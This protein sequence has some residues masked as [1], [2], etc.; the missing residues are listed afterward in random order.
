[1]KN[2]GYNPELEKQ[3]QSPEDWV[4][5]GLS[6]KCIAIIKEEDRE[7]YLPQ[8]ELQRGSEDLMDC[9]SRG[10]INILETKFNYL[11]SN[12]KITPA[13]K[14]WLIDNGYFT[15]SGI[16]FSDAFVAI[17]SGTTKQGNSMKAPLEAI[18]KNGLVP[19]SLLPLDPTMTFNDYHNPDRITGSM[20]ALGQQFLKRFGMNYERVDRDD[21]STLLME[22]LLNV[23][24]YAWPNPENG[25]YPRT[26]RSANHVWVNF[27]NKYFAFDNYLDDGK[28]EDWIK[29]LAPDYDFVGYG[30]RLIISEKVILKK[31]WL[32][33][34][35][36]DLWRFFVDIISK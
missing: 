33:Q 10:P 11:V 22:D 3:Q 15:E 19:K 16:S 24:G 25:I 18:R 6:A 36:S 32:N 12:N 8:G 29:Q 1:M 2:Y 5:G 7:K 27:K 21:F 26:D 17:L 14:Q 23:A 34:I 20:L 9:A 4:F 31:N 28:K 35:I 30:Y 13:N